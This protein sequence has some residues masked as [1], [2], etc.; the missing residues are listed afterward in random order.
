MN[1]SNYILIAF[2]GITGATSALVKRYISKPATKVEST[3]SDYEKAKQILVDLNT[4]YA[5]HPDYE[6][7]VEHV[8]YSNHSSQIA[9]ESYQGFYRHSKSKEHSV[10][11]GIETIHDGQTKVVV[12]TNS[13]SITL[14]TA[15]STVATTGI[16]LESA[17]KICS[18]IQIKDSGKISTITLVFSGNNYPLS[19]MTVAIQANRIMALE[20][21]HNES[22][23][24]ENG[25]AIKPRTKIVY[26]NYK[27][28]KRYVGNEFK[29]ER[30]LQFKNK[31][32]IPNQKFKNYRIL[33]L[34][35]K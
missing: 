6:A 25:T 3:T 29:L 15:P 19:K 1:K 24:D 11:M 14:H 13:K 21:W 16:E 12:D 30:I 32:I 34:R 17:L 8:L 31:S 28:N 10:L 23:P 18:S 2:L 35:T 33:D 27:E 4:Y 5:E 7:Q 9:Y 20:M 26:S 22:V